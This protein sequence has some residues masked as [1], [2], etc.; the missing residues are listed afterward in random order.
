MTDVSLS[1]VWY[2][3][4]NNRLSSLDVNGLEELAAS[5]R[6]EVQEL[7]NLDDA[8]EEQRLQLLLASFRG[9][10]ASES[11]IRYAY[12]IPVVVVEQ[13]P[14]SLESL[15]EILSKK[16]VV[17][18]GAYVGLA[19]GRQFADPLMLL[20]TI[21][22]SMMLFGATAGVAAALEDGLRTRLTRV[23]AGLPPDTSPPTNQP[24][25]MI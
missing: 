19:I 17:V 12:T 16:G 14:P 9:D 5:L 25:M 6:F 7:V 23:I 8:D 21:P 15:A 22:G 3:H 18:L 10:S 2:P 13:S 11:I 4:K 20:L 1:A 24:Q